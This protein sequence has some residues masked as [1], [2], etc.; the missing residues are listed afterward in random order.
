[1]VLFGDEVHYLSHIPM[2]HTPLDVQLVMRVRVTRPDGGATRFGGGLHTVVPPK[3]DL[4]HLIRGELRRFEGEV[5]AGNFEAGGKKLGAIVVEIDEILMART[6][7]ED[8]KPESPRALALGTPAESYL[9]EQIDAPTGRDRIRRVVLAGAVPADL[10]R[11]VWLTG[12]DDRYTAPGGG[13]VTASGA[14]VLSCLVGPDFFKA[15]P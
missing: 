15:C 10:T 14:T 2:F 13:E 3:F 7:R 6:L 9:V 11:G 12:S 8:L 4:D 1:M 5:F